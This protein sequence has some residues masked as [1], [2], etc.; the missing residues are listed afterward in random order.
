MNY[1]DQV[2]DEWDSMVAHDTNKVDYLVKLLPIK[3][4]WRILDVGCGTGFLV[5][6]LLP[7]IPLGK[8]VENDLSENMLKVA[9]KK[10]QDPR[11]SFFCGDAQIMNEIGMFDAVIAFSMF[12]HF[13][14]KQKAVDSLCDK[15][16]PG[17]VFAIL[18]AKSREAL[19]KMHANK[20]EETIREDLLPPTQIIV[21]WIEQAG[22]QILDV[23]DDSECFAIIGEKRN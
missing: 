11:V 13:E 7:R 1:F 9:A 4:N 10:Y 16:R 5:P 19:N 2:A 23:I 6:Y 18:H 22:L 14:D 15:I 3:P 20:E 8:L 21:E 12:P 17:G